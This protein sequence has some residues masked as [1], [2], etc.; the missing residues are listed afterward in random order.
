MCTCT[1]IRIPPHTASL[2][3]A[4]K[5]P[6]NGDRP[7]LVVKDFYLPRSSRHV[8]AADAMVSA[9]ATGSVSIK[10]LLTE[11]EIAL[12][13]GLGMAR[14]SYHVVK[15]T[16]DKMFPG[17]KYDRQLM[18]RTMA[19][20]RLSFGDDDG[21][22][23]Q[24]VAKGIEIRGK[25]GTF[26]LY[27][28]S[29]THQVISWSVQLPMSLELAKLYGADSYFLDTTHK[30]T[31]WAL[32]TGPISVID[33][34]GYTAPAGIFQVPEEEIE[35]VLWCLRNLSLTA[36]GAVAATDG[37][38]AW[39]AVIDELGQVHVEDTWHNNENAIKKSSE[40]PNPAQFRADARSAL[41]DDL[42]ETELDTKLMSMALYARGTGVERFVSDLSKGKEKKCFTYTGKH[43]I[44]SEKG[45]MSRCEQ[46]MN[47]LKASGT[48]RDAM[49]KFSI[50][51]LL[52]RHE[53]VVDE[54]TNKVE[55]ELERAILNV[56]ETTDAR[57]ISKY[58]TDMEVNEQ[59]LAF[60]Y[61]V[62]SEKKNAANPFDA[63]TSMNNVMEVDG[64]DQPGVDRD[65]GESVRCDIV[66]S[67][68][69][70]GVQSHL[71]TFFTCA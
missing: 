17:R 14:A 62:L 68:I 3:Y 34:F 52:E 4:V 70:G 53:S 30:A 44:C 50:M 42:G 71:T 11:Q 65:S 23:I 32:K 2:H 27:T 51:E 39:P 13:Q 36:P 58:V 69:H 16:M 59:K 61:R 18:Y 5:A 25:G 35:T 37:G 33:A 63:S 28:C 24:F 55:K 29:S 41:Y 47:S 56:E 43:F 21:S 66:L 54:Y 15:S 26:E 38:S 19:E 67:C 9:N 8:V 12:L 57:W 31:R 64:S 45:G 20:G 60:S 48:I 49:A 6:G 40:A 22:F 7:H 10:S 1:Y 46:G